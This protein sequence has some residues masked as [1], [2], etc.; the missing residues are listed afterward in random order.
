MPV[1]V[2][3]EERLVL[4]DRTAEIEPVL[5]AHIWILRF[6]LPGIRIDVVVEVVARSQCVIAAEPPRP[7]MP[8]VAAALGHHVDDR[9]IVAAILWHEVAGDHPE[10]FGRIRIQSRQSSCSAGYRGIV[11]V[12]SI[13]QEIV[14][15]FPRPVHRKSAQVAVR[16]YG[17]RREQNQFVG[18]ACKQRQAEDTFGI[19]D[20][21]DLRRFQIHR[22]H[23]AGPHHHFFRHRSRLQHDVHAQHLRHRELDVAQVVGLEA[24][25]LRGDLVV[26]DR[27]V[28][29]AVNSRRAAG[30]HAARIRGDI[31]Y[32]HLGALHH[33][34]RVVAHCSLY[35][36][37]LRPG[38]SSNERKQQ[39]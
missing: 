23:I 32:D 13:Q 28:G 21:A 16:L 7:T 6:H 17:S 18:I 27:K 15:A 38:R 12:D 20:V 30:D 4:D 26:S 33:C 3:K 25:L 34:A 19:H 29:N 14:I 37:G 31:S 22:R 1:R 39:C 8:V 2:H 11:V 5:V 36:T 10:L 9:A 24:V 35:R